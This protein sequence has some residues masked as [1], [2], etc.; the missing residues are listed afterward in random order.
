MKFTYRQI[1]THKGRMSQIQTANVKKFINQKRFEI[2]SNDE[3]A[4]FT[5]T[6]QSFLIKLQ[7]LLRSRG[8]RISYDGARLVGS[9][10][11]QALKRQEAFDLSSGV[12]DVDITLY[13]EPFNGYDD[14]FFLILQVMEQ[15]IQEFIMDQRHIELPLRT[16][17]EKFFVERVRIVNDQESWSLI[18]LATES[19]TNID[20]KFVEKSKRAYAFSSDSFELILNPLINHRKSRNLILY[21]DCLYGNSREA[22]NHLQTGKITTR[23]PE[24]IR[25]GIFR[26]C[27]EL[28]KGKSCLNKSEQERLQKVFCES[29]FSE[30][31]DAHIAGFKIYLEKFI[32]KHKPHASET[33]LLMHK[34]LEDSTHPSKMSY[35]LLILHLHRQIQESDVAHSSAC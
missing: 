7:H 25:R 11:S 32:S 34:I 3:S 4:N 28:S 14:C 27:L 23:N 24:E 19:K 26:Y 18:T 10:A 29:F 2:S 30:F 20:I 16:I 12:N 1:P 22:L 13:M 15:C 9:I 5:V 35:L 17:C 6:L 33:L 21:F 8:I 31:G